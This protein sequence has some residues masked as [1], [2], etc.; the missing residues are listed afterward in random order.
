MKQVY[1]VILIAASLNSDAQVWCPDGAT[2]ED[3]YSAGASIGCETRN[4]V[5]DTLI[6]A[7]TAQHIRIVTIQY[8]YISEEI[9]TLYGSAFT[10]TQD[11]V[12]YVWTNDGSPTMLWDTLYWFSAQVGDHWFPPRVLDE[13]GETGNLI[14]VLDIQEQLFGTVLLRVFSLGQYRE[15]GTLGNPFEMTERIGTPV[16][17]LPTQCPIGE[18]IYSTRAYSDNAGA[19]FDA[20]V[21]SVCDS[22]TG[23]AEPS[24]AL[25]LSVFP[26]PGSDQLQITILNEVSTGTLL[27]HD[28]HGSLVAQ[29][30]IQRFPVALNTSS[31]NSG[32]YILSVVGGKGLYFSTKWSKQ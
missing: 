12:V 29:Q 16:M 14:E 22:F 20:G 13:C 31:W 19:T 9:D 27:V 7:F 24:K 6:G 26:N 11:S 5:G 32:Q 10:R 2:W 8:D 21:P 28:I 18:L 23:I 25:Q 1:T 30:A 17:L 3:N 4:Y 15:D